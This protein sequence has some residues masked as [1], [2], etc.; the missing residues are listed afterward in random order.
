MADNPFDAEGM[1]EKYSNPFEA[2]EMYEGGL[3]EDDRSEFRKGFESGYSGLKATG[4]GLVGLIGSAI[5]SEGMRDWGIEG[6]QENMAEAS[7]SAGEVTDYKDIHG[8][9]DAVDYVSFHAGSALPMF[10]PS[11][12]SGGGT[13]TRRV[14]NS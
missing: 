10:A 2:P 4:S 3:P 6:Y 12:L 14:G 11:L 5:G 8:V 13:S 7:Q 9:M 1:S